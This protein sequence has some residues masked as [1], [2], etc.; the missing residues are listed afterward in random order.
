VN[1]FSKAVL[2]PVLTLGIVAG[3]LPATTTPSAAAPLPKLTG[4][5][6]KANVTDVRYRGR[7]W[8]HRHHHHHRRGYGA[9]ALIGGIVAGA[10]IAGAIRE[11]R[12]SE[13]DF[14]RCRDEFRSFNPRTGTYLTYDGREVVCPYLR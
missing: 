1:K 4:I 2:V 13:S 3:T 12:A 5:D 10:L 6:G 11:S 8:R 9:G 7:G 14:D